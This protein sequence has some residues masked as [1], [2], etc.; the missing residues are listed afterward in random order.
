MLIDIDEN[1]GD[2]SPAM[3]ALT[4]KMRRFVKLYCDHPGHSRSR[5][6]RAA[7]YS[8]ASNAA[9]VRAHEAL[10]KPSVLR[11]IT[12]EL[13]KRFRSHAALGL[14]VLVEI[15]SDKDHPRR[16]Q[17]AEALLNRGGFHLQ[18]EQKITVTH[19]DVT[20]ASMVEAIERLADK[21]GLDATL[22]IG[23]NVIDAEVV[24]VSGQSEDAPA[25]SGE[26]PQGV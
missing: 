5:L 15:A 12:E 4:P 19:T 9:A 6:A 17:A 24:E 14:G 25:A 21:H 8:N 16:L 7:G 13:E 20:A 1:E 10:H 11:A 22:L 23:G 26:K 18:S 3:L 2:L